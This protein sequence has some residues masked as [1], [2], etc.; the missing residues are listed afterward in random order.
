MASLIASLIVPT[1]RDGPI[2]K[3]SSDQLTAD[4]RLEVS[5]TVT[6]LYIFE[7]L[8]YHLENAADIG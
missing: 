3:V 7:L 5:D 1:S 8:A 4:R 6:L 2:P